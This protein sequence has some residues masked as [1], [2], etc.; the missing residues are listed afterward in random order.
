MI[1]EA[2]R[3]G[4][5]VA[6]HAAYLKVRPQ[7]GH[8][9][10]FFLDVASHLFSLEPVTNN[11][12]KA[13]GS[14]PTLAQGMAVQVA[15]A[16]LELGASDVGL[17]R[18]VAYLLDVF[19]A[20]GLAQMIFE[21]V[22]RLRP[23]E[24][25]SHRDLALVL[26]RQSQQ[27]IANLNTSN[28][29]FDVDARVRSLSANAAL[30][31]RSLALLE[32]VVCMEVPRRFNEIETTALIELNSV[33][34]HISHWLDTIPN[35]KSSALAAVLL[36]SKLP[37]TLTSHN[38]DCDVR[39]VM[40]WDTDNVDIDLHVLEPLGEE[41]CYSHRRTLIGGRMSCDFTKGYGPEE[42]LLCRAVSGTYTVFAKYY[43]SH[44]RD[45]AGITTLLLCLYKDFGRPATQQRRML[46]VRL[47]VEGGKLKVDTVVVQVSDVESPEDESPRKRQKLDLQKPDHSL[48]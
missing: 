42:Y 32:T 44:R 3:S 34:A 12:G 25:Q 20:W 21:D 4:G 9:F 39:V 10:A 18:R 43:A 8:T 47:P 22:L 24:P 19:K 7:Y 38:L 2:G 13:H 17:K 41:A 46:V 30:L 6:C 37:K 26:F 23:D 48:S 35:A 14:P 40:A 11:D 27:Q 16:A 33:R 15:T 1:R 36:E 5:P 28:L 31:R 45:T 29:S